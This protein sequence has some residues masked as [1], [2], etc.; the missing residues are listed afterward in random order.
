MN[1]TI[2][3]RCTICESA[4]IQPL[5]DYQEAYLHRC[6]SCN[7]V[8]STE[9]PDVKELARVYD[10]EFVRTTY[11]SP[12]TV[13]RYEALLD[14]FEPFRKTNR[15]LDVGAGAGF[16]LAIA[17]QRGWE[18]VGT[19]IS[20][21]CVNEGQEQQIDL[22][23]GEL[24][25]IEFPAD[26]FDVI[27]CIETL[28]HLSNPKETVNEMHRILRT[29][30]M[31]YITTPNFNAILRYRL[32][33]AYD[34]ICYPIHLCYFTRK[35]LKKLFNE[36]RFSVQ[37]I[38]ATGYSITRKRTSK[39]ISQQDYVSETSDDELLRHRLEHNSFLNILKTCANSLLNLLGIGDNL[40]GYFIK[41]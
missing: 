7:F 27:V 29:G 15:L 9:L 21:A 31:A 41:L 28:E 18:V 12:I 5:L 33:A 14:E 13:K 2:L 36:S 22:R 6:D 11:L 25:S 26:Y 40:K 8:F 3:N 32:K 20:T 24:A 30:G 16:F 10:D 37:K 39:G 17:Q 4:E 34:V 38:T 19:E 35:T 1:R 23:L